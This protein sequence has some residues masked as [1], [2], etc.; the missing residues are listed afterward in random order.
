MGRMHEG[1]EMSGEISTLITST[2]RMINT[3]AYDREL[4][5]HINMDIKTAD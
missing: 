3:L 4:V 2:A 5:K 1:K